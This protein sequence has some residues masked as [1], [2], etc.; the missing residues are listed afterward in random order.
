MQKPILLTCFVTLI[1]ALGCENQMDWKWPGRSSAAPSS[2]AAVPAPVAAKPKTSTPSQ[3][4][5]TAGQSEASLLRLK[6]KVLSKRLE[7]VEAENATLRENNKG[8]QTLRTELDKQAFTI[9]MQAEDLKVLRS[10][11][12]ER[13]L[14]KTRSERLAR[15]LAELKPN[16]ATTRPASM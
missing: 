13:D 3:S 11:A 6:I 8:I 12:V 10:A 1:A 2:S 5:E 16:A 15:Q 9:K 4:T 7:T 14:Y